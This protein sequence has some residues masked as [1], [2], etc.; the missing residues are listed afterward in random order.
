M[1]QSEYWGVS[2]LPSDGHFT[3]TVHH[4]AQTRKICQG[5]TVK[6]NA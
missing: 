2:I 5:S 3:G 1:W 6:Y 4:D